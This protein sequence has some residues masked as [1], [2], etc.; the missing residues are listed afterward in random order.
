MLNLRGSE[1][2]IVK[3]LY[4]PV[5]TCINIFLCMHILRCVYAVVFS[6]TFPIKCLHN[7]V[8][9]KVESTFLI[10]CIFV[11]YLFGK[12]NSK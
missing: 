5:C 3:H 1:K 6:E 2:S 9:V 7:G 10:I 8:H 4:R 12:S 11:S